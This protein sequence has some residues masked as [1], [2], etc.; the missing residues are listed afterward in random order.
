MS[1]RVVQFGLGPI[2]QASARLVLDRCDLQLVGALDLDPDRIGKDVGVVL[3]GDAIGAT[4]RNDAEAALADWKPDVVLHTTLSFLDKIEGQLL[5]CIAAGANVVS[6][7]E[8]L[9]WPFQRDAQFCTRVDAAAKEAGVSVVGTGVNPGFVM[10]LFPVVLSGVCASVD[11]VDVSRSVDAGRRR[12]PLQK[13]VGAG[14]SMDAFRAKEAAGGFG[15][16]GMVESGLALAAGF[17]WDDAEVTETFGPH[18]ADGDYETPHASVKRG[19]VAGIHQTAT[20]TVDGVERATLTLTMAVGAPDEDRVA[21]QGSPNL[22]VVVEG[23]TFGDTATVAAV[24]NSAAKVVAARPGLLTV[25][26][27]PAAAIHPMG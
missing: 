15:H 22:N 23:G 6:S 3:G 5:T 18:M 12:G 1:L 13:K 25:L 26:D 9:F 19:D 4:V 21:I 10:D 20:V 17:G 2:G 11:R 16:I 24:V 14:L 8:E 27:L 7:S